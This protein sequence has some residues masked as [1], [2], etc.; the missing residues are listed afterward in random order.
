[1]L[2]REA[3]KGIEIALGFSLEQLGREACFVCRR[4]QECCLPHVNLIKQSIQDPKGHVKYLFIT[5]CIIV[6]DTW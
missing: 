6:V 1:M 4:N 5:V 3:N 2:C